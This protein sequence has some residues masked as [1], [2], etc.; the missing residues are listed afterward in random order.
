MGKL[1][2]KVCVITGASR[3]IGAEI[4]VEF[5]KEG[6]KIVAAARTLHE[7]DHILEGSLDYTVAQIKEA[8]GEATAS[9]VNISEHDDCERLIAEAHAAYG[10][11]DVLVNNA[12]LTYFIPVK[13]YPPRRWM[14]SWAVNFHAPFLLSQ[15]VLPEMIGRES[16]SIVNISSG[17]AIGPGR[18]P[19]PDAP[20]GG[21][22]T[23]YGAEKAALER[24]TQG[25]A[26]EVYQ[27]G[28]SV[29]CVSPSQ[30]VPTPGTVFHNL[31][32]GMDDPRGEDP[33]LMAKSSL[34]LAT[35]P[36]DKVT[37]RVTYSQEI[38]KE[39]GWI[40]EGK[41]TGIDRKGSGYS[42]V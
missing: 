10:Q 5:A 28:I 15:M 8:G 37:G 39:F 30:V 4:A 26:Q 24:F 2:G 20:A 7:G 29:T 12:A 21:G 6:G 1:D 14:R 32:T 16:G 11:I 34:L 42:L 31:V 18:G 38:L 35:E 23:C 13:D 9:A 41:G 19:Y 22:G 40:P 3:G 33:N 25:L 36:L 27:F 17:A